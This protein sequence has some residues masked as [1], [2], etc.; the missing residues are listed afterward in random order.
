MS[1]GVSSVKGKGWGGGGLCH[2]KS[3][4][5]AATPAFSLPAHTGTTGQVMPMLAECG[6]E[7]WSR[8][9]GREMAVK[10]PGTE[11]AEWLGSRFYHFHTLEFS[12]KY[13]TE[14]KEQ[15]E[16]LKA[17]GFACL[18]S[19]ESVGEMKEDIMEC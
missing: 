16:I 5:Q 2:Q 3:E 6:A 13:S 15:A 4:L 17:L 10:Q 18:Y 1:P 9:N 7:D 19:L 11:T 12:R 8:S 14:I